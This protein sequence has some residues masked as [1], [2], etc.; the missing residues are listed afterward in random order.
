MANRLLT[1]EFA[2]LGLEDDDI[3]ADGSY[4]FNPATD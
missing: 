1:V 2:A 3:L 4:R